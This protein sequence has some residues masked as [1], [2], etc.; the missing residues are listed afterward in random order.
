MDTITVKIITR[1]IYADCFSFSY[2]RAAI[3]CPEEPLLSVDDLA[4][5][6]AEILNYFGLRAVMCLGITVGAYILALFDLKYSQRVT[7]LILVYPVCKAPS[8]TEW[9][10]NKVIRGSVDVPE[11]Y[12]VKSCGR[13]VP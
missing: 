11:S 3:A 12:V 8:W 6:I 5:Q 1:R 7:G 9:F 2:Q 13:L 4:D 10:W